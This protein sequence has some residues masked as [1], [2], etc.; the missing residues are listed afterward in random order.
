VLILDSSDQLA[1]KN[2]DRLGACVQGNRVKAPLGG[3]VNYARLRRLSHHHHL[4]RP[5]PTPVT[6]S[7]LKRCTSQS[8]SSIALPPIQTVISLK[9]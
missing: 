6:I 3:G 1:D 7:L 5:F 9:K 8:S 2:L 4:T